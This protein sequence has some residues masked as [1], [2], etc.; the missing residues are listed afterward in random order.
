MNETKNERE[1]D[2]H[3]LTSLLDDWIQKKFEKEI[4]NTR[5]YKC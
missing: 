3:I 2:L 1:R 5:K 4:T